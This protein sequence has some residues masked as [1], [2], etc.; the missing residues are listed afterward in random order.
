MGKTRRLWTST[1]RAGQ[2]KYK[3]SLRK[4][5]RYNLKNSTLTMNADTYGEGVDYYNNFVDWD[6][7]RKS[8]APPLR[9]KLRTIL[10]KDEYLLPKT[11]EVIVCLSNNEKAILVEYIKHPERWRC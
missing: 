8:Y 11:Y 1:R 5:K 6:L 2:N 3:K 9:V 7:H 10:R 4:Q